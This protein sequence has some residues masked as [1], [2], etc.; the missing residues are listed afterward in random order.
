MRSALVSILLFLLAI[1]TAQG[2]CADQL[3][4]GIELPSQV[5]VPAPVKSA[6]Q[7]IGINYVNYYVVSGQHD[8]QGNARTVN[9]AMMGLC[10][11]LGLDFS[12][13][14]HHIDPPDACVREAALEGGERFRGVV[15]DELEHCRLMNSYAPT[16]LA[17]YKSFTSLEDAFDKTQQGYRELKQKFESL[18]SSVTATHMWPVLTHTAAHEGF[19]VCA[20]ICKETYSAV[21]LAMAIG[22]AKQYGADLW[23]DCD[24]WF[25]DLIPGHTPEEFRSNLLLAYWLGAD[26]TYVEGCGYNLKPAGKQGIPFSL[27]TMAREDTYQLTPH[28]EVLR[29]FCKDYVPGHPRT[30]TFRDVKPDI[31]IVRYEDTCH[32]QRYTADWPD[33]LYGCDSLTSDAD[34]EA[35]LGIWNLLTFGKTGRDGL[36]LF[37]AWVRPSGYERGVQKGVAVSYQSRPVQADIHRFFVPLNGVVVYDHTVGYAALK[38]IPLIFVTGKH[39]SEK[40][41]LA[42]KR[43]VQDGATCVMWGPLAKQHGY[44]DWELGTRVVKDGAGKLVLAEDFGFREV[45]Q[46]IKGMIGRPDEIRYRFGDYKVVLRR[47]TDNKISV[48]LD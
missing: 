20:K 1:L 16:P 27:M 7:D 6:L 24:L 47:V 13:A 31:A 34:T 3:R 44:P 2:G 18:N 21:Q 28:G 5:P 9:N 40:T 10:K 33:R 43:C 35:W 23:V 36:S 17:D 11:D 30:W 39:L 32:G 46:E 45:Y 22:A 14:C 15:F 12:I 4:I 42:V 19:T 41:A 48:E 37:K 26:L 25:W 29:W 8:T 38:D